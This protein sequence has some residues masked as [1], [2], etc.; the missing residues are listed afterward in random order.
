MLNEAAD[1]RAR[2][3]SEAFARGAAIPTGPGFPGAAPSVT[4]DKQAAPVVSQV[5]F[6]FDEISLTGAQQS[7][8]ADRARAEGITVDELLRRLI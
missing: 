7:K 8:L 2:A 5:A 3:V 6:D 1:S 4:A